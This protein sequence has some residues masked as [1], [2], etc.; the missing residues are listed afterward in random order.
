L[1]TLSTII[2]AIHKL[3]YTELMAK[4]D[5][6]A[7]AKILE[8]HSRAEI[9]RR[10]GKTRAAVSKWGDVVPDG[11]LLQVSMALNLPMD[12]VAPQAYRRILAMRQK[13]KSS[14]KTQ[15]C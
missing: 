7:Y 12:Q 2:D 8:T 9:A 4:T 1:D 14:E 15:N 6:E 10:I 11:Y 3:F 5:R 13:G